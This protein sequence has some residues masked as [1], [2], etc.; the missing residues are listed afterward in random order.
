MEAG[1]TARA[2]LL[3][4]SSTFPFLSTARHRE[5]SAH[6]GLHVCHRTLGRPLGSPSLRPLSNLSLR[7]PCGKY[8]GPRIQLPQ[9]LLRSRLAPTLFFSGGLATSCFLSLLRSSKARHR[10]NCLPSP[11]PRLEFSYCPPFLPPFWLVCLSK[12]VVGGVALPPSSP[13]G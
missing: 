5:A 2:F 12:I 8:S 3:A 13:G 7:K 9:A 4:L 6:S 1:P 10:V 11:R